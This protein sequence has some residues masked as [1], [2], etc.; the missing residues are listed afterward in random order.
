MAKIQDLS[1][2]FAAIS[3]ADVSQ[4]REVAR[5]IVASEEQAGHHGAASVLAGALH[6]TRAVDRDLGVLGTTDM[7]V[8][9]AL[10]R[11]PDMVRL[12]QVELSPDGRSTVDEILREFRLRERLAANGIPRR[13]AL[14]FH[15]PPGS[16]KTLT[17]QTI[18]TELALP[19]FVVRFENLVGSLLGQTAGRIREV[20]RFAETVPCVLLLDEI[21]VLGRRR[22]QASDVRELDR[23]VVALMQQLDLT[24]P[25][26]LIIATTN[27]LQELDQALLRRFQLSLAFPEPTPASLAEFAKKKA[28]VYRLRLTKR[29]S[30]A[31][32]AAESFAAAEEIVIQARR[33]ELLRRG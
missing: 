18:G 4:A 32:L 8:P 12:D 7:L 11:L 29:V 20:F 3:T 14:L 21:D 27:M 24:N 6:G 31:V 28:K 15:G 19:V 26:G 10:Y 2:L 33:S 5:G 23:V 30:D 16:G 9:E 22:G 17:A 1:K 13:T 25:A